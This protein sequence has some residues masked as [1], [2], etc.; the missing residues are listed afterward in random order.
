MLPKQRVACLEQCLAEAREAISPH[1]DDVFREV[2]QR[3]LPRK[4][5]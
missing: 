2:Q 1:Y 3:F 4:R 5:W